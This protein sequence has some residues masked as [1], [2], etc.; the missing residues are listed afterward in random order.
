MNKFKSEFLDSNA[1]E[2]YQVISIW[3][4][5]Q[6]KRLNT[7][8]YQYYQTEVHKV[9]LEDLEKEFNSFIEKL[10]QDFKTRYLP[11]GKKQI[12]Q[13][14]IDVLISKLNL[15]KLTN[16]DVKQVLLSFVDTYKETYYLHEV[17]NIVGDE[18]K[19]LFFDDD[20]AKIERV[21]EL[22]KAFDTQNIFTFIKVNEFFM[23]EIEEQPTN[24]YDLLNVLQRIANDEIFK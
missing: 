18:Y 6:K 4:D 12:E 9:V 19:P 17:K 20:I 3:N 21:N 5:F 13:G 16:G 15:A 14:M 24:N 11:A 23:L 1:N 22:A 2:F 10:K 8:D 7:R